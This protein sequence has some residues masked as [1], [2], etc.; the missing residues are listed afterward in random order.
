[1]TPTKADPFYERV[2]HAFGE[3]RVRRVLQSM[4]SSRRLPYVLDHLTDEAR[5]ELLRRLISDHKFTRK[6][7][8]ANRK[9]Y[10]EQ[11]NRKVAL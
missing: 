6:I 4:M 5:D 10:R 3:D 2:E 7:N 9:L 11:Q 1:M 8:A